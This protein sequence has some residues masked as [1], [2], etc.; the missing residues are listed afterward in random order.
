MPIRS[1]IVLCLCLFGSIAPV[2]ATSLYAQPVDNSGQKC[3]KATQIQERRDNI[4]AHLLKAVSLAESGRWDKKSRVNVAW[5]WTVTSGG[6]GRFYDSQ[7]EA[8]AEVEILI[9]S[10]VE[11]IDVGC[12]QINLKYHP[13][14]FETLDQAF[15][16]SVNAAYAAKFL[17][18]KF[19]QSGSWT[20]AVGLYHSATPEKGTA[21]ARKV[22][23]LWQEQNGKAAKEQKQT[24]DEPQKYQKSLVDSARTNKLN[25]AFRQR[26]SSKRKLMRV[27]SGNR[28]S[29]AD[30]RRAELDSWRGNVSAGV[31]L[32]QVAAER[33]AEIARRNKAQTEKLKKGSK[34]F[35]SRRRS[36][37]EDWRKNRLLNNL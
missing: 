7:E 5:P 17:K 22:T 8:I 15:N 9:T 24:V 34:D 4:P 35:A 26:I 30:R 23:R 13:D 27:S 3:E 32:Q 10:G 21:Y 18:Q 11:N 37:L 31:H 33:K 20:K 25:E 1:Y 12:M 2:K 28:I 36:Q 16:P 14:A 29:V 19:D 6:E